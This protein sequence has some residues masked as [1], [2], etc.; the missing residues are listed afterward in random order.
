MTEEESE[1]RLGTCKLNLWRIVLALLV[2]CL[3]PV[4]HVQHIYGGREII[5]DLLCK[6]TI[7]LA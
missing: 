4:H 5:I 7:S 2:Y 1:I 3:F 6:C